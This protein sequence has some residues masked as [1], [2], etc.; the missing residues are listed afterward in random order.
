MAFTDIPSI[1]RHYAGQA[2][3][4]INE[5]YVPVL[6]EA[7]RYDRQAGFFDSSS[8]VQLASGLSAFIDRIRLL[9]K[10]GQPPMRLI[11]GATWTDRDREA[12][13]KGIEA[14][15]ESL[16]STLARHFEPSD[17]E[18]RCL[19][20]PPGWR[21]EEDQIASNRLGTLAWMVSRE[22]LDVHI[23]LP[24]DHNGRPYQPGRQGALY[25]PK[26]GVLYDAEG[27]MIAFQ[28]SVNETSAAWARNR[29]KF[30]VKRSWATENDFEDI[31]IEQDEFEQIWSGDDNGLLVI[32]LP[33][34]IKEYL[35]YFK[36]P[37]DEPQPDPLI[38]DIAPKAISEQER[39]EARRLLEAPKLPEGEALVT[40][41]IWTDGSP[42][43]LFPHQEKV[44]AKAIA[45]YPRS[46]LFCDEVGLGKTIEAGVTLRKL[47][48]TGQAKRILIIAPRS[49]V[50]Q[51]MEELREKF[52]LTAWFYDGKRLID[53]GG[54][55]R[56]EP[57]PL[58]QDGI[59]IVSRH[60]IAR[61]DRREGVLSVSSPWDL[62]VVDEA[63]AARQKVFQQSEPNQLLSLLLDMKSARLYGSLWLLTATPMQLHPREVHDLL[64]LCGLDD[65]GWDGWS[66][67]DL[68]E[69]FFNELQ[70]F[71]R[72]ADA[73]G[74]VISMTRIAVEHGAP[75]LDPGE[76]PTQ[77]QAFPWRTLVSK[78][79]SG[80]GLKLALQQLPG[81]L[82]EAMT[83]FL[84]RQTPLAVHMFRHTRATLRAYQER[85]LLHGGLATRK[86]QDVP[87]TLSDYEQQL[88]HR[89]DEMCSRFYRL[90][91]L[92]PNERSG[93]GFLM[94]VFRKRLSSSFVAF[95]KSLERRKALIESIQERIEVTA[96]NVFDLNFDL[97]D[98][99]DEAEVFGALD[100]ETRR[101]LNIYSDPERRDAL[102]KERLYLQD[103]I[104]ALSQVSTDSKF[105]TFKSS[106]ANTLSGGKRVIVFSQY[107]D[108]LDFIRE[109][110]V[111]RYGDQ[112]ACYSGR[113][114]EVW[115][116][117]ANRWKLVSKSEIKARSKSDHDKSITI[118]LGTEAAS[119]GLN[120]QQFSALYNYDLPWNP[121]RVEQR[122]GRIDRIGQQS[123]FVTISN[124]YVTG[125]IEEDTYYT[126][127]TRIRAFEEVVGPLQP[128]LSEMPK[129]FRKVARG[130]M[131]MEEARRLLE[132][133]S[134][135][136]PEGAIST[137]E[138]YSAPTLEFDGSP[139]GDSTVTQSQ[140]ASWCLAHPAPGMR[141]LTVPEPGTNTVVQDGTQ[142]CLAITWA[143]APKELG[144]DSTEEILATFSGQMADRHPPTPPTGQDT[145]HLHG[146][147]E[148]VRLLTWGDPFLE[149]WLTSYQ[150]N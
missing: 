19:G 42:F 132:A 125:T 15:Q 18:C 46:Y 35:N 81:N 67:L 52:A 29:E 77:W 66:R 70:R 6:K 44:Y 97:D 54:R 115:D 112:I 53:V 32:P 84:S 128:I 48:I 122:I 102:E 34:A 150:D 41:P 133:A 75:E 127:K 63:H 111:S 85:G 31:R 109:R 8:L 117:S 25:H 141:I 131:E 78:I 1:K 100:A 24:L 120:L 103:Y 94:A 2:G 137:L 107:L 69:G 134:K 136:K 45:G 95:L 9:P 86:P 99:D 80:S 60:L 55:T 11:T 40:S 47:C 36:P 121:M 108:T 12:Y 76:P 13:Q 57:S 14:L 126:L 88:Y 30:W 87:V 17:D 39:E 148:G 62:V 56:I 93:V 58:E 23:A 51:W 22:L 124:L 43:R 119:E 142:A 114:G 96:V 21:P 5:F 130:E 68:F 110:L 83:P 20:L 123:P 28:G 138:D 79:K 26:A 49:L 61:T 72:S 139:I 92:N 118:L 27:N 71:Q 98:E 3:M 73:R 10:V 50:R 135:Q 146:G 33:K 143:M 104:V 74:E 7:V 65:P 113:G 4:L 91:D 140:L 145:E 38:I 16:S 149:A 101:L 129:I 37:D 82:A 144:I 116:S 90:A 105:E 89:I 59:V 64:L 106:L 147:R